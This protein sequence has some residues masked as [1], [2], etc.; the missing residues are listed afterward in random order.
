LPGSP[1]D[2]VTVGKVG[3]PPGLSGA[4]VVE[5]PS[6]DESRFATGAVLHVDGEPAQVTESKRGGGGRVVIRLDRKVERGAVLQVPKADLPPT[7]DDGYYVFQLIGLEVVEEGGRTLGRVKDVATYPAND[8]L[9]VEGGLSLPMVGECVREVDLET[10]RIVVAK[11]F[12][13]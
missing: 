6:E 11:G 2:F 8:V 10:G 3:R 13:P 4:F 5:R 1:E 12:A 7:E 9:E